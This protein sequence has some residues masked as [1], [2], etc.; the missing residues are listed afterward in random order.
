M[1]QSSTQE[2]S[3]TGGGLCSFSENFSSFNGS[4]AD[5]H[6][7]TVVGTVG[8]HLEDY[9]GVLVSRWAE[10]ALAVTFLGKENVAGG[11]MLGLR[12]DLLN[13]TGVVYEYIEIFCYVTTLN[14]LFFVFP[15]LFSPF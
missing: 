2:A 8:K 3:L 4:C 14:N 10:P 5:L 6:I 9:S 11:T 13:N 15:L 7:H 1:S 12:E